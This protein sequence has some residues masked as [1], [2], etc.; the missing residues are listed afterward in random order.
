MNFIDILIIIILLSFAVVG[1]KR[2]V[3]ESLIMFVGAILVIVLSY[4]FK[5]IIGNF[6]LLNLPFINF[7]KF[8]GGAVT[9]NV[10][11]YQTIAFILTSVVFTLAYKFLVSITGIIEKILRFTIV[12][13]I[14]SKLLGLVV[15]FLE[16]YIIV[17]VSLFILSQ[18]FVNINILEGSTYATK[19]VNETPLLSSY[20]ENSLEVFHE[21]EEVSKLK[22]GNEIDLKITDLILKHNVTKPS[23]MQELVDKKKIEVTGIQ[24]V[25]DKYKEVES[26]N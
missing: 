15:G 14:P 4:S 11:L 1:F 24:N 19:I 23:I 6:L 16:G 17:Y 7:G 2:G 21:I 12:L 25:I 8:M 5:D 3:F 9:L 10:I 26:N 22:D 13:G 20:M 18:P